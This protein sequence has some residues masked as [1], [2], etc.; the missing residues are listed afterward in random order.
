MTGAF[1][2]GYADAY[3][4]LYAEKDYEAESQL[5]ES[6]AA[7]DGRGSDTVLDLGCGTGRHAVILASRGKSVMG[8]DLSPEMVAIAR[9]RAADADV[10]SVDF[11]IGDVRTFRSTARF[12]VVLMMFA[13]LGYQTEDADVEATLETAAAHLLPGGVLI[14]DVWNG[15]GVEAIGPTSRIKSVPSGNGML[16]RAA[17]GALDGDHH[18]CTVDYTLE[19][20]V[21]D[22]VLRRE[23]ERHRMRYFF[24]EELAQIATRVGLSIVRSGAF[25]DF[26]RPPGEDD[27]NAL[28]VAR[29]SYQETADGA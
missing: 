9:R 12:D 29:A 2:S 24:K 23:H 25:P 14:F 18:I 5:I 26:Q 10:T 20:M 21:G 16:R 28:Y 1:G 3:D 27:W 17:R 8:V 13:V 15:P 4:G 6:I 22:E 7:R 11:H 19:W